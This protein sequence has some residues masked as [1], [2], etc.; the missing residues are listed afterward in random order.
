MLQLLV[1]LLEVREK[2]VEVAITKL[3]ISIVGPS[4]AL[5]K[6]RWCIHLVFASDPFSAIIGI[7]QFGFVKTSRI[8]LVVC[9]FNAGIREICFDRH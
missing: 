6:S 2:A 8:V 7:G 4:S 1:E 9:N 3:C 5:L